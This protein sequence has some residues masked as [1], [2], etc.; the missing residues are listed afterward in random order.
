MVYFR[1]ISQHFPDQDGWSPSWDANCIKGKTS[2][3]KGKTGCISFISYTELV[4]N[5]L[6][7][8]AYR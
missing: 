3:K 1:A 8:K 4:T 2:K 7:M 6:H 5:R